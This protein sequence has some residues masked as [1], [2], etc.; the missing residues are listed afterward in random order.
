M[1]WEV[2]LTEE[3]ERWFLALNDAEQVDVLAMIDVLE[4]VGPALGRP[5]A[6]TLAGTSKVKNL[7]ELRIQHAGKPYRAF[8]AF[9]PVRRAVLLCGGRKD[10]RKN[11][12]F[13]NRMIKLAEAEFEKYLS[14][15]D[16]I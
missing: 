7:K 12:Q 15:E 9:D 8:Y 10:G 6:D 14:S 3:F 1:T 16:L 2:R 13:Y 5:H 4:I 11:K